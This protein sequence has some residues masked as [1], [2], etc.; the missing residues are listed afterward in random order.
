MCLKNL[1]EKIK[2]QFANR[3]VKKLRDELEIKNIQIADLEKKICLME[4]KWKKWVKLT[5]NHI[6]KLQ[7]RILQQE[8]SKNI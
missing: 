8:L 7:E 4:D 3:K 5:S 6:Q 1:L 2:K